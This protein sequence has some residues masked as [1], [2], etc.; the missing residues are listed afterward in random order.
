MSNVAKKFL[1]ELQN[2]DQTQAIETIKESLRENAYQKIEESRKETLES[3]GFVQKEPENLNESMSVDV[4]VKDA[5][6][7]NDIAEDMFRGE[8]KTDGS[9]SFVFKKKDVMEDF[10]AE[11]EKQNIE[12]ME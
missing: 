2:G 9:N 11:L 1:Q 3:Y 12:V 4:S 6:K 10:V 8:Y 7:A 5:T